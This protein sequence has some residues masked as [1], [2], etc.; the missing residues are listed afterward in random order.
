MIGRKSK[1]VRSSKDHVLKNSTWIGW[2][3]FSIHKEEYWRTPPPQKKILHMKENILKVDQR[4]IKMLIYEVPC[5][6]L[7]V[8]FVAYFLQFG[9]IA[10]V[11]FDQF[12]RARWGK[13]RQFIAFRMWTVCKLP[14]T[15]IKKVACW[16]CESKKATEIARLPRTLS[17][18]EDTSVIQGM[19]KDTLNLRYPLPSLIWPSLT[20]MIKNRRMRENLENNLKIWHL[21]H[22]LGYKNSSQ[23]KPP[24]ARRKAKGK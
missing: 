9:E 14:V 16:H 23:R 7:G 8:K 18:E 13:S 10:P 11:S 17:A 4:W 6:I 19:Q 21:K 12:Q 15:G 2:A 1:I 24:Q 5:N 3:S 22:Y 20:E